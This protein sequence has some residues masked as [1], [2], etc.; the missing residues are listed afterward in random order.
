[1]GEDFCKLVVSLLGVAGR[2][3]PFCELALGGLTGPFRLTWLRETSE[4]GILVP[5]FVPHQGASSGLHLV[6]RKC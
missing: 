5:I 6:T 1:M 3:L 4:R 2:N